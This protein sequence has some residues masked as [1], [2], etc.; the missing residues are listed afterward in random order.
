MTQREN[1]IGK[2]KLEPRF[3]LIQQMYAIIL[4]ILAKAFYSSLFNYYIFKLPEILAKYQ[5]IGDHIFA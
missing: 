3:R 4:W 2:V 5:E 1:K